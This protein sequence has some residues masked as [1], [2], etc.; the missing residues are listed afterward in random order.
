LNYDNFSN[1]KIL[2]SCVDSNEEN[3]E[4]LSSTIAASAYYWLGA[5]TRAGNTACWTLNSLPAIM[6]ANII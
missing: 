3:V 4:V 1:G 6:L 5:D 2:D